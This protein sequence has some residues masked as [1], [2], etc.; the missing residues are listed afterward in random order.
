[1]PLVDRAKYY[2]YAIFKQA[3]RRISSI[4]RGSART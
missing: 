2:G 1:M 3:Q 4:G